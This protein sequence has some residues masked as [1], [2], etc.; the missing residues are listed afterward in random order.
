MKVGEFEVKGG[1]ISCKTLKWLPR[2]GKPIGYHEAGAGRWITSTDAS[3]FFVEKL[4]NFGDVIKQLYS[5]W[6]TYFILGE[7]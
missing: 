3:E 2:L 7:I 4:G 1:N 6:T 5:R